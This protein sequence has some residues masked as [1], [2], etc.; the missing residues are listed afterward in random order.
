MV[1]VTVLLTFF[2]LAVVLIV[3]IVIMIM[4]NKDVN[5]QQD[6]KRSDYLKGYSRATPSNE[7]E[8]CIFSTCAKGHTCDK[9][10][11]TC[12][13]NESGAC[14]D[15]SQCV[16]GLICSGTCIKGPVGQFK[17]PCPC[18]SPLLCVKE[19]DT[20][21]NNNYIC[22]K[23]TGEMCTMDSDCV[24]QQCHGGLCVAT[25]PD[26]YKCY[27]NS[28]CT[29]KN[30]SSGYC[31]PVGTTTG[32]EK[33]SC[34]IDRDPD[35]SGCT[36]GT[37]CVKNPAIPQ[38]FST[39]TCV[40]STLGI[41]ALC[42]V[43]G[44]L[45]DA[46][47]TCMTQGK[48]TPCDYSADDA[49]I[50][51][52]GFP[53][54]RL[55]SLYQNCPTGTVYDNDTGYCL[56]TPSFPCELNSDCLHQACGGA[57][58]LFSV[59]GAT[60]GSSEVVTKLNWYLRVGDTPIT[61]FRYRSEK[62]KNDV[63]VYLTDAGVMYI[64]SFGRAGWVQWNQ[65]DGRKPLKVIGVDISKS[66]IYCVLCRDDSTSPPSY[67]VYMQ[68][69]I[70]DPKK[71]VLLVTEGKSTSLPVKVLIWESL[72][73]S[74]CFSGKGGQSMKNY[75]A[76]KYKE[77]PSGYQFSVPTTSGKILDIRS[78]TLDKA[79]AEKN[80]WEGRK[81]KIDKKKKTSFWK[82]SAD[83]YD[84]LEIIFTLTQEGTIH[85]LKTGHWWIYPGDKLFG[86]G[87]IV[88]VNNFTV[89]F[90]P[91]GDK[92]DKNDL[93]N[94]TVMT[95][96]TSVTPPALVSNDFISIDGSGGNFIVTGPGGKNFTDKSSKFF[97]FT[98]LSP[99]ARTWFVAKKVCI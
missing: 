5:S 76:P 87:N 81:V 56:G 58:S 7:G 84:H 4:Y 98:Y 44:N 79:F 91:P 83:D 39:G 61:Y 41:N 63:D 66:G 17:G 15:S 14:D 55:P 32:A 21:F 12:K 99:D 50:C 93:G 85:A 96:C 68:T 9:T 3:I 72:N 47:L 70:R 89:L 82:K 1:P 40:K 16:S 80:Q 13:I 6:F 28:D 22:K 42:K 59:N 26:S 60:D 48:F 8:E 49:C 86:Y 57:T 94:L 88:R 54:P 25:T 92:A 33:A 62:E 77:D 18:E 71:I 51:Q 73:V 75:I 45:C 74:V 64:T 24:N 31:Q 11:N 27:V 65:S 46:N 29:S 10:T 90:S 78:C 69:D 19:I 37:L 36:P 20:D 2:L 43:N 38:Y 67:P 23:D 53:D 97:G 95:H 34:A 52:S 35:R 30:C